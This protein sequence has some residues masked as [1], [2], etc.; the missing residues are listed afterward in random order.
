MAAAEYLYLPVTGCFGRWL[1]Y[2][3]KVG[4][5]GGLLHKS[6]D[7]IGKRAWMGEVNSSEEAMDH[8]SLAQHRPD[9]SRVRSGLIPIRD[10]GFEWNHGNRYSAQELKKHPQDISWKESS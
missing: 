9:L 2:Q 7:L 4:R 8:L 10:K 6:G 3:P 1:K 5:L